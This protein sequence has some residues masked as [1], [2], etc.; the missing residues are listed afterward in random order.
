MYDVKSQRIERASWRRWLAGGLVIAG[1]ATTTACGEPAGDPSGPTAAPISKQDATLS[2]QADQIAAAQQAADNAQAAKAQQA[3]AAPAE[4]PPL[5]FHTIEGYGGGAITPMAYL[6][7]PGPK[8][9]VFGKPSAAFSNVIA[10]KKNLQAVTLTET[11]F[12]RFELGYGLN[13]FGIGTL[14]EDIQKA[15][16]VDIER[17]EVYLHNFNIRTALI[18]EG[19]FGQSWLPAI[20]GGVHFKV[21]DG[22]QAINKRLGG[23]LSSIGYEDAAGVDFTLTASKTLVQSWTLNRPLIVSAGLRNSSASQLGFLGFGDHRE[24]TFEGNVAYLPFDWLLV[25][26]EFRQKANPYD[27][28][29]GL[30][31]D[32]DN[33]H[34]IDVSWIINSHATLVGGWGGLGELANTTENGAWFLQF[35]YEF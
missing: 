19:S 23:A 20:T 31:G 18:D 15:T 29:P 35:K 34:A 9:Q 33:W 5:P 8:D 16:G 12:G 25:A 4:G 24:F 14:D 22:I 21:N 32:E 30:V 6:V 17:E 10:G 13:R 7:N 11:L 2:Q 27:Q 3:A 26:Y 1:L 28:I